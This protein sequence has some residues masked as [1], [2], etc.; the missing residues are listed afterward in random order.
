RDGEMALRYA[1]AGFMEAESSFRRVKGYRQIPVLSA[2]LVAE[3][4]S[5]TLEVKTA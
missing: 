2:M 3:C 1:A 4:S 5:D